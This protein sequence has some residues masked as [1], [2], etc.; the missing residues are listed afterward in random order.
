M[1]ADARGARPDGPTAVSR[2]GGDRAEKAP[3]KTK[4][5]TP[6]PPTHPSR[7]WVQVLT[8]GTRDPLPGEWRKMVRDAPE[9]FRG[10]K[11]FVTPWRS[12]FRL[13]T[14]PF[15]SEAAAQVFLNQL[16]RANVDAFMWT[17]A[18]GQAV[19]ALPTGR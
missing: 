3:G 18:A 17:S 14:G 7:I 10:K 11:A 12:N 15:E 4:V 2:T 8:G 6:P 9:V 19:D 1:P 16:R 5:K 13:L